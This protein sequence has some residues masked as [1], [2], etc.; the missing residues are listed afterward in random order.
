L[1]Q[2]AKS[3]GMSW[4]F[5]HKQS[6]TKADITGK[7]VKKDDFSDENKIALSPNI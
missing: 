2:P 6:Q 1:P 4:P 7:T 3:R 5:V